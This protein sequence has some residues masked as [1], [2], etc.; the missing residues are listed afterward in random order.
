MLGGCSNR[1]TIFCHCCQ[2]ISTGYIPLPRRFTVLTAG[3]S[4]NGVTTAAK[5]T[6]YVQKNRIGS[7]LSRTFYDVKKSL[8]VLPRPLPSSWM[9]MEPAMYTRNEGFA[10]QQ[11]FQ[12]TTKP[13]YHPSLYP[14][15]TRTAPQLRPGQ[16]LLLRNTMKAPPMTTHWGCSGPPSIYAALCTWPRRR[17]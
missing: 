15:P 5:A 3:R 6:I 7:R 13:L 2:S 10:Y 14:T 12:P 4:L 11:S 9:L 17:R 16:R 8:V 1:L